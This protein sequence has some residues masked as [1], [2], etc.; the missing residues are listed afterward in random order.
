MYQNSTSGRNGTPNFE[1]RVNFLGT[2]C[3]IIRRLSYVQSLP[4]KFYIAE[5]ALSNYCL[6][7][8]MRLVPYCKK[9]WKEIILGTSDAWSMRRSSHRPSDS[10]HYIED[11]L[12]FSMTQLLW[13][14]FAH[15]AGPSFILKAKKTVC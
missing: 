12:I 10:A 14:T 7:L 1:Q 4:P 6:Q 3:D 9:L 15:F 2:I 5:R 11:C 13:H 8:N